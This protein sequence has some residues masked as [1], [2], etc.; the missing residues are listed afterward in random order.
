MTAT[1]RKA[2]LVARIE[3]YAELPEFGSASATALERLTAVAVKSHRSVV[4]MCRSPVACSESAAARS[5]RRPPRALA[6]KRSARLPV[7][8]IGVR[9]VFDEHGRREE[10]VGRAKDVG[11]VARIAYRDRGRLV[12]VNH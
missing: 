3:R 8:G 6:A 12:P 7:V 1:W 10:V 5:F 4:H 11:Q 2:T 9:A